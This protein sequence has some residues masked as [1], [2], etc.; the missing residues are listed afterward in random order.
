MKAGIGENGSGDIRVSK[1]LA[2]LLAGII[3]GLCLL[4]VSAAGFWCSH[5]AGRLEKVVVDVAE[6]KSEVKSISDR[7]SRID[8][9]R[10]ELA[11]LQAQVDALRSRVDKIEK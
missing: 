10:A 3:S 9:H 6:M 8:I 7:T 1:P 11:A 5:M 4:V 2:W